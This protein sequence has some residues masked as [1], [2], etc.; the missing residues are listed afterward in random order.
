M[1]RTRYVRR[2]VSV[3]AVTAV[4]AVSLWL[5]VDRWEEDRLNALFTGEE[6]PAPPPPE[7]FTSM[8]E[9]ATADASKPPAN[10]SEVS[11]DAWHDAVTGASR[12]ARVTAPSS[13]CERLRPE[14]LTVTYPSEGAVF[15]PNLCAPF[16]EWSDVHNNLWQVTLRIPERSLSWTR[17]SRERRWRVPETVWH[18]IVERAGD[19]DVTLTVRGIACTALW[20][21]TRDSVHVSRTVR[22]RIARDP[23]DN[24]VVYRLV[25]PPFINRKTPDTFVRDVR[26]LSP[27]PFLLARRQYCINCH[28]FSSKTGRDGKMGIQV[29]YAGG[30]TYR[31]RIYLAVADLDTGRIIKTLLPFRLQMTT[32][33]SWSPDAS[34]LAVS[35]NQ[36]LIS[37]EPYVLEAQNTQQSGS[38]I[39]IVD[40]AAGSTTLLKGASDSDRLETFPCWTPDGKAIVFCEAPQRLH[41]RDTKYSLRIVDYNDGTGG[42]SGTLVDAA[43]TGKSSYY[44]RFSPD[45]RWLSFVQSDFGSLIKSSSDLWLFDWRRR[46]EPGVKPQRLDANAPAAADSWYSWSSNSRWIVF[47]SKRD[48]GVYARLYL[49][50]ID[51]EGHASVPVRL[52]IADDPLMSF[53]IPEFVAEVPPLDEKTL[54][55]G[56][57]VEQPAVPMGPVPEVFDE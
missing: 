27:Q 2:T 51:D 13:Y 43:V 40:L 36:T 8:L 29:R 17:L 53:N 3:V 48:D 46:G 54:F 24:A 10:V 52:P 44:P 23:C 21:K 4:V 35:A 34:K 9:Y 20:G 1:K 30:G 38:D 57:R 39:A 16:F 32:F 28:A 31:H 18:T 6:I 11:G 22:F 33:M 7:G 50:H 55:E 42:E 25:D 5:L 47:T 14:F 49:T 15:P 26:K 19:A 45:G 56:V 37:V 41:P 12:I